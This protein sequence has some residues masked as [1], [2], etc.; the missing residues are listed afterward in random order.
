MRCEPSVNRTRVMWHDMAQSNRIRS[1]QLRC[2]CVC[3]VYAMCVE[4]WQQWCQGTQTTRQWDKREPKK[5]QLCMWLGECDVDERTF[6]FR[7]NQICVN[8]KRLNRNSL[9]T[10]SFRCKIYY[11]KSLALT[12]RQTILYY[13]RLWSQLVAYTESVCSYQEVG[14]SWTK[15]RNGRTA[16][17]QDC[18]TQRLSK[19]NRL[20]PSGNQCLLSIKCEH[21]EWHWMG[22]KC[23]RLAQ[24]AIKFRYYSRDL[25]G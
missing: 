12:R 22:A 20:S 19:T 7:N 11:I 24:V 21:I 25:D 23:W 18:I 13:Y 9:R 1:R 6:S 15:C 8:A 16:P 4:W 3:V 14:L 5:R 17:A 10:I 2:L